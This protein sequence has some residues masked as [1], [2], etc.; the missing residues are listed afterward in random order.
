MPES[1]GTNQ[2]RVEESVRLLAMIDVCS[3]TGK[4]EEFVNE[5]TGRIKLYGIKTQISP[6]QLF[7][8]RDIKDQQL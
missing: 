8:L 7:W 5:I 2:D 3:L 4:N 6:R 1:G